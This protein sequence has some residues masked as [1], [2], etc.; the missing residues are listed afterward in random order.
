MVAR[1]RFAHRLGGVSWCCRRIRQHS[2]RYRLR[3]TRPQG[4]PR[5][6]SRQRRRPQVRGDGAAA[7]RAVA[8][9]CGDGG[10]AAA[11]APVVGL[12]LPPEGR[13]I[14]VAAGRRACRGQIGHVLPLVESS[15]KESQHVGQLRARDLAVSVD[16]GRLCDRVD[17]RAYERDLAAG[18][19]RAASTSER[20]RSSGAAARRARG[21]QLVAKRTAAWKIAAARRGRPGREAHPTGGGPPW[22]GAPPTRAGEPRGAARRGARRRVG[23]L[24]AVRGVVRTTSV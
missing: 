16:G 13:H 14:A 21:R 22:A 17:A 19:Q 20:R 5:T 6:G 10:A 8:T 11:G 15:G 2:I 7:R 4:P 23:S 24:A 3:R 12:G 18:S 1:T 9:S